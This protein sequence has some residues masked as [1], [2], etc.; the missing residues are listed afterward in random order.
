MYVSQGGTRHGL[1]SEKED[2][3]G[4]LYLEGGRHSARVTDFLGAT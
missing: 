4:R 3:L 1:E 2:I